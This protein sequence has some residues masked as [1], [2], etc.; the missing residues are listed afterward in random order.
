MIDRKNT[1]I[2]IEKN[3][4]WTDKSFF[5][6]SVYLKNN[7]LYEVVFFADEHKP[8]IYNKDRIKIRKAIKTIDPKK[9]RVSVNGKEQ[10]NIKEIV[11]FKSHYH[12][13]FQNMNPKSVLKKDVVLE[14]N[15]LADETTSTIFEYIKLIA[16]IMPRMK[17]EDGS[18]FNFLGEQFGK[19]EFVSNDS[20]LSCYLNTEKAL[21]TFPAPQ[22]IIYPFGAN[23]SQMTAV[24]NALTHEVSVIEGPPGTGKTQTILNLIAN[25]VFNGKT[26][27]VVSNNNLAVENVQEKLAKHNLSFICALLGKT[28]NRDNFIKS[29]SGKYPNFNNWGI[30]FL[31]DSFNE[32][33]AKEK[34][35]KTTKEID[36]LLNIK[37]RIAEINSQILNLEPEQRAFLDYFNSA[38]SSSF[39]ADLP[40]FTAKD[41]LKLKIEI[42]NAKAKKNKISPL[43]KAVL[44]TKFYF[45]PSLSKLF[46][47]NLDNAVLF[48]EKKFYEL[49]LSELKEEKAKL[50]N[51]L[52]KENLNGKFAEL[53]KD[54]MVLFEYSLL[55]KY[56]AKG[57][58]RKKFDGSDL[59]IK[60]KEVV[61]EYPV[62]LSSTYSVRNSLSA[63]YLYDYLIMDE[64]SQV[65]IVT[66]TLALSVAK[67]VVVVGDSKQLPNIIQNDTKKAATKIWQQVEKSGK[68][69]PLPYCYHKEKQSFLQSVKDV[70]QE[71]SVPVTLL[72]EH[73]RCHPKIINFCNKKFYDNELIIMTTDDGQEN[74]MSVYYTKPLH[75]ARGYK[76]QRQIDVIKEEVLPALRKNGIFDGDVGIIAPY[77]DQ[78]DALKANLRPS[79][80]GEIEI[81]T[82]HKFQGREKEAII[83]STTVDE[84]NDFVD[85]PNMLNVAVSRAEKSLSLVISKYEKNNE[86]LYGDLV[87]YIT[88]NEGV[89]VESKVSSVFDL[90]YMENRE[91]LEKYFKFHPRKFEYDSENLMYNL[92]SEILLSSEF[93]EEFNSVG[94]FTHYPL[95][96]LIKDF[97][98]LTDEEKEYVFRSW[99]HIDFLFYF[100]MNNFP[101]LAVEVDG[102]HFHNKKNA[103][104]YRDE[105]KNSVFEKIDFPL[106]RLSTDGSGEREKIVT[107]LKNAVAKNAEV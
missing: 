77:N 71:S 93:E 74:P 44:F 53:T 82:V 40:F 81:E 68:K 42:E 43:K 48:L 8:Y 37:Y 57:P 11:V 73:Y 1:Q 41:V 85:D 6:K 84:I 13:Y 39:T 58:L 14:K 12:I 63:D 61:T 80:L 98:V 100:K 20:A 106:L 88:Y 67:N 72:R 96:Q 102:A 25:I 75:F 9:Y 35:R 101:L 49:K 29:Q 22:C 104:F 38:F 28:E 54:S 70:W 107:A 36:D 66:G 97:S 52:Q 34:V 33:E 47:E 4:T 69:I 46:N 24:E 45:S 5:V 56:F 62:I 21:K 23:K 50:E 18:T 64:S 19:I 60:S 83:I 15:A 78:V 17:N 89:V 51:K 105:T 87:R 86:T 32:A 10:K 3:G 59:Q 92:V 103:Q 95:R 7:S 16:G 2:L 90:L 31:D 26:V 65:D 30:N 55:K 99:T 91:A 76:N 27:A 94:F 79:S